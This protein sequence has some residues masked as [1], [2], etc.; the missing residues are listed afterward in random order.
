MD[1]RD[2]WAAATRQDGRA[3]NAL[4][5]VDCREQATRVA[6]ENR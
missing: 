2:K 5:Q 1:G 6:D 3:H 4:R